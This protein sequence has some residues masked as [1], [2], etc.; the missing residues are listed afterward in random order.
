MQSPVVIG[1]AGRKNLAVYFIFEDYDSNILRAVDNKCVTGMKL[2]R[3]A[4]SGEAGDQ[5]GST[6]NCQRPTG[7]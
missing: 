3:L 1:H 7:K 2:D 5:I 4:V 6:S